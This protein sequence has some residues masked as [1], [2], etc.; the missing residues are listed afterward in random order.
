[1]SSNHH[2]D[3]RE[4]Y[5]V[6]HRGIIS[7]IFGLVSLIFF[8]P[9]FMTIFKGSLPIFLLLG[10]ALA[11][12]VGIDEIQEKNRQERHLQEEKLEHAQKEI[13]TI[14]AQAESYREELQKLKDSKQP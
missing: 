6:A 2:L 12:F 8:W 10:G 1:M 3:R 13:E 11:V 9:D 7:A 5:V 4:H 14:R